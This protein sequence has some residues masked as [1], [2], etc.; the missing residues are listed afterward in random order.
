[1]TT[2]Q[3][4]PG[5]FKRD[6]STN[7]L[8]DEWSTPELEYL[9]EAEWL[10]TEKVDGTNIRVIWDG[11]RVT[12]AGRT[13]NAQLPVPLFEWLHARFGG[14]EREQVFEQKFGDTPAVLYGEGYGPKIQSGGKYRDD[15]SVVFYDVRVGDWWLSRASVED[16]CSYFQVDTVPAV[17]QCSLLDAIHHVAEGHLDKS[18]WGT[19]VPEGLV[20]VTRAGLLARNGERIMVKIKG[21]DFAGP[22]RGGS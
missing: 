6:P 21:R 22:N 18:H 8:T 3:K 5:P 16:V 17:L 13:D 14:P 10:F 2:Y 12:F 4:I 7:Q 1:M 20:G 19:F 11:Y 9:K 15:I